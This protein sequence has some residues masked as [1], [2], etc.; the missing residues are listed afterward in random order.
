[1]KDPVTSQLCAD[2]NASLDRL[3]GHLANISMLAREASTRPTGG[4]KI[5]QERYKSEAMKWRQVLTMATGKSQT[6]SD[7]LIALS[8]AGITLDGEL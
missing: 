1:M 5:P 4:D 6:G 8:R 2:A 3:V 7:L